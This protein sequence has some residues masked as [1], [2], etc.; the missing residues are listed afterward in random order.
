MIRRLCF[1]LLTVR[2][3][4]KEAFEFFLLNF[5]LQLLPFGVIFLENIVRA[6]PVSMAEYTEAAWSL[7]AFGLWNAPAAIRVHASNRQRTA[8]V[9]LFLYSV[10]VIVTFIIFW[11]IFDT[12]GSTLSQPRPEPLYAV[13]PIL[14]A[15]VSCLLIAAINE[16][17]LVDVSI[18]LLWVHQAQFSGIYVAKYYGLFAE[19]GLRVRVV[20][21]DPFTANS[22]L[23]RF[24]GH[25]QFAI[26]SSTDVVK[27]RDRNIKVRA[28]LVI[29]PEPAIVFF[30][31]EG[32]SVG[33][34][35]DFKG[36]RVAFRSGYEEADIL[37]MML[38]RHGLSL[39]DVVQTH[40]SIDCSELIKGK[41]DIAA[42]HEAI[43]PLVLAKR[44]LF[45]R[46]LPPTINGSPVF[47]DTLVTT[48]A[49]IRAIPHIVRAVASGVAS[50]WEMVAA[51]PERG[52][53]GTLYEQ[54]NY[55]I[56]NREL[57]EAVQGNMLGLRGAPTRAA[58]LLP[59][60]MKEEDWIPIIQGMREAGIIAG[61]PKAS[62][63]F[64]Y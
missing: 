40:G 55:S 37:K 7:L 41:V 2:F 44:G 54:G 3:R 17:L 12:A 38:L 63:M 16:A 48:E 51:H 11:V 32:Q 26:L 10:S 36:M 60:G 46:T 49:V 21:A 64:W 22:A 20:P 31:P 18:R 50:G 52:L 13:L 8:Q 59:F 62:E 6:V 23:D 39:D 57:Q 30:V 35:G 24:G 9:R 4:H 29:V 56:E 28:I 33:D 53:A 34:Y 47:A 1:L 27:A 19:R 5:V 43:E 42:G 25:S 58:N 14:L 45:V 15:A 61:D